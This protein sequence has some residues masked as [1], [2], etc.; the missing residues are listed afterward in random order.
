[1]RRQAVLFIIVATALCTTLLQPT[2]CIAACCGARGAT[3]TGVGLEKPKGGAV[4]IV[5][6]H[7]SVGQRIWSAGVREWFEAYNQHS[8]TQYDIVE[9]AFPKQSPYGWNNFP[10]DYWN[11]W[12]NHAGDIP[13]QEEPTLEMLTKTYDVIIFKHCFPVCEIL[14]DTGSPDVASADKRIENYK[15][16]YAALKTAMHRF[17]TTTFIVWTGAAQ[18]D[19]STILHKIAALVRGR[20]GI[21]ERAQGARTFFEWVR[22]E[23]DEPGD[24]IYLWD[25]YELETEGGIFLKKEYAAGPTDSHPNE[26]FAKRAAPLFCRRIVNVIEGNGDRTGITGGENVP[27]DT[28]P[29]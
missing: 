7:H 20:S 10:Y 6:L 28:R 26:T 12:V 19:Y 4:K 3:E 18:V 8:G 13:Y 14:E 29:R 27:P 5:F 11:I 16:Q 1:M 9:Q 15:L 2:S 25:F 17:P 22:N 21:K 23:W 24:N